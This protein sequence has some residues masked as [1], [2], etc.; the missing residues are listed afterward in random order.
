MAPKATKARINKDDSLQR[1]IGITVK[2]LR[3]NARSS[4]SV[5][6]NLSSS[7]S[8]AENGKSGRRSGLK[9]G[10]SDV[11]NVKVPRQPDR[12]RFGRIFSSQR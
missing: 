11:R 10:E 8:S 3:D 2:R 6:K 1:L 9:D 12:D 7:F 4:S 5:N